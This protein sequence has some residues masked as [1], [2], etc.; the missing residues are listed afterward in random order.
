MMTLGKK[1]EVG[2]GNL[3]SQY[4]AGVESL[5]C[6]RRGGEEQAVLGHSRF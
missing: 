6:T 5:G 4:I 2:G 1:A 3:S